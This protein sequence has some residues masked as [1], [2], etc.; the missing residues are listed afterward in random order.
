MIVVLM[1]IFVFKPLNA[2][3]EIHHPAQ[4]GFSQQLESSCNRCIADILVLFPDNIK[5]LLRTEMPFRSQKEL[6][7][8]VSLFGLP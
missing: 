6:Y 8:F 2:V 4:T 3:T 7:N 1:S 5:Q